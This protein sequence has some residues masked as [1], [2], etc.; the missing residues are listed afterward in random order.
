MGYSH[1]AKDLIH[2]AKKRITNSFKK[3]GANPAENSDTA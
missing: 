1:A 3:M 2:V